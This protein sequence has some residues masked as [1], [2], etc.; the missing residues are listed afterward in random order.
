ML[1]RIVF[2]TAVVL[3]LL[4]LA[5]PGGGVQVVAIAAACLTVVLAAIDAGRE[6]KYVWGVGFVVLAVVLNPI[7]PLALAT[8][9]ALAL[10]GVSLAMVIAW[11][12]VLD[13]AIPS[14][15]IAQVL[16]PLDPK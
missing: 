16:Y 5:F 8:G 7:V 2:A 15:S 4:T 1:T 11:M 10:L 13:R 12:V 14:R 3:A 6:G 9:Y